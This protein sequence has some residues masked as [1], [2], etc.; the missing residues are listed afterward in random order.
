M[1]KA[2]KPASPVVKTSTVASKGPVT[3]KVP[4]IGRIVIL[5]EKGKQVAAI[6]AD[7]QSDTVIGVRAF[8][9]DH[10]GHNLVP[11]YGNVQQRT[12]DTGDTRSW[13]WPDMV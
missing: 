5:H 11:Y 1:A 13:D 7:V 12:K 2:S 8:T 6:I 9:S 3:Q 4:S 10:S